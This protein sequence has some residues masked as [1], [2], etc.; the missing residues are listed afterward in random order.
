MNNGIIRM[1]LLPLGLF[2]KLKDLSKEGARDIHNQFR[3]K[4]AKIDSG[5]CINDKSKIAFNT[6]VLGNCIINNS[7][8]DSY[9]YLGK[10]CIIQNASIGK[11]C[12]IASDVLIGLGKHPMEL[13]STSTLFYRTKNTLGLRLIEK[14]YD[15]QE[16]KNIE[17]GNDVW[18]GT[19]AILMD[20]IK[21]GHGAI[22]AASSVVTKD[23]PPYAIVAG[24]P[25]K[26]IK[27]RFSEDKIEKLLIT[28]WWNWSFDE[29]KLRL[30]EFNSD[31]NVDL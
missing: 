25:A 31:Q 7:E 6:H 9:S 3:F 10:N 12:S 1:L 29:I 2:T 21:V 24:V 20:G 18:I 4:K 5:C 14:D 28:K 15:F 17:I 27:Y 22:I 13:T 19:R 23:V 30:T 11:F 8:L 16:Y 26:V